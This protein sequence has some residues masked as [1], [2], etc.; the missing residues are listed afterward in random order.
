MGPRAMPGIELTAEH[1]EI[2]GETRFSV[3]ALRVLC[4]KNSFNRE[5]R[6]EREEM[7]KGEADLNLCGLCALC[8]EDE[9]AGWRSSASM[10]IK[11]KR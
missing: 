9:F 7:Q 2:A 4:G 8:G 6:E 10:R 1:A 5:G 3:C 11:Q